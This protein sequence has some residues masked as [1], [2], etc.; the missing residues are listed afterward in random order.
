MEKSQIRYSG[1]VLYVGSLDG[2][3]NLVIL[4]HGEKYHSIYGHMDQILTEVSKNVRKGQ[5]IGKSGDSG[6]IIGEALYFELR[7]GGKA[8]E[9]T[10]WFRLAKK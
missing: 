4:G 3:G 5:I 8:V 1:K 6:S 2:Y 9:P 7:Q 10:A